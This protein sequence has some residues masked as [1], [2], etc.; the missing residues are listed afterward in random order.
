MEENKLERFESWW[1]AHGQ[2]CRAGGGEYEK[3]FAFRAWESATAAERE[4][5]AACVPTNWCDPMLTGPDAV[6]GQPADCR[7]I[8]AVLRG[9]KARILARSN[10]GDQ[11]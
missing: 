9:V 2:Y 11:R 7:D 1:E 10:V 8:E 3:T 5:C 4:A 6:I